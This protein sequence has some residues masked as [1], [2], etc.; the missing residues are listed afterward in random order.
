MGYYPVALD[1]TGRPVLV[2]GG[3]AVAERK[4]EGLVAAGAR[5]TVVAP[6]VTLRLA[7]LAAEERLRHVAREYRDGDV[8]GHDLVFVAVGDEAVGRAVGDEARARGAWVNVADDPARCDFI[9]PS[10]LRRGDLLVAVTTGGTSPALAR[11]V[12]ERLEGV[13]TEEY[14]GLAALVADV[15]RELRASAAS[16]DAVAWSRALDDDLR[17]L[18]R[19]GRS[20]EA[21]RRLR[22]RLGAA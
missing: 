6:R 14:A 13:V 17:R 7:A 21:R 20:D 3:G 8:V 2:V 15:R 12:R 5:V 22:Q 11:A 18:V 19:D 4:V 16:P 1:V 10:V 9:L